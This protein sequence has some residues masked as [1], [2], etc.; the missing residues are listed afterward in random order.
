[1]SYTLPVDHFIVV[2]V[3][4]VDMHDNPAAI[5]GDVTW[6]A[7]NDFV[8]LAVKPDDSTICTVTPN[9]TVGST[10]VTATADVDLGAGV[11]PLI[12]TMDI[13]LVAGE[14]VSGTINVVGDAQPVQPPAK[15]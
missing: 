11:K 7:S 2:Q 13:T 10:Q 3:S 5:D 15:P 14:A 1:M 4:Y 8:V 9:G 12:T 6:G